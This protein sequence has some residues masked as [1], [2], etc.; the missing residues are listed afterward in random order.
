MS[1]YRNIEISKYRN[2]EITNNQ[3]IETE[4][5]KRNITIMIFRKDCPKDRKGH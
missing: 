3:I 5:A 4:T 1:K 2:I